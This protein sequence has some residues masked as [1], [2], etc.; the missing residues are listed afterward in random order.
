MA[1]QVPP[2]QP[3]PL[4]EICGARGE[5]LLTITRKDGVIVADFNEADLDAAA[6]AFVDTVNSMFSAS[7]ELTC[8]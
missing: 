8:T 5:T 2:P 3:V 4:I 1:D 6:R 7:P